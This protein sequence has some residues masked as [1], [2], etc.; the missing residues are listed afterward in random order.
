MKDLEAIDDAD[1]LVVDKMDTNNL[2]TEEV[3]DGKTDVDDLE[4]VAI[5]E[6]DFTTDGTTADGLAR[7]RLDAGCL[8][9]RD[10]DEDDGDNVTN[11]VNV[12]EDECSGGRRSGVRHRGKI[13]K[14]FGGLLVDELPWQPDEA[15]TLTLL[16]LSTIN[17]LR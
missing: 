17:G 12:D 16:L 4:T 5:D 7:K 10:T 2:L 3:D 11:E 13:V 1:G 6:Y 9:E 15:L 14:E 8:V